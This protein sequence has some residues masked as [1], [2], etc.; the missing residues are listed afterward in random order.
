MTFNTLPSVIAVVYHVLSDD[1]SLCTLF[2]SEKLFS[3]HSKHQDLLHRASQSPRPLIHVYI[4]LVSGLPLR[5]PKIDGSLMRI[6]IV[7]QF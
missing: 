1:L 2:D 6:V 4:T 7:H 3:E 5:L